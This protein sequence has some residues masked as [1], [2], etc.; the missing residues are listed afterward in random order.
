MFRTH[1]CKQLNENLVGEEVTICG[2]VDSRRDH[3]KVTFIDLR[4]RYGKVQVV[5]TPKPFSQ[6]YKVAK[7]LHNEYVVKLKAEVNPRPKGTQN[8]NLNT[9]KIELFAKEL[10]VISEA[11]ELPFALDAAEQVG[12]DIRYHHRYLDL[13]R[14]PL[15]DNFIV[16]H[17]FN[18]SFRKFLNNQD[19][20]EIETPFLTKSTPEGAR[21]FI[22][23]SRLQPHSFYALPQSP[24]LFKQLLMIAGMDKYYQIVRCFR[25]EDLRRD[26]Q[27]EFSQLDM[28]MS[29]IKEDAILTLTEEMLKQVFKEV[30]GQEL[31]TPFPRINYQQAMEEHGTDAPDIGEGDWRF[32]WVLNFPL[33]EFNNDQQRW[34]SLHHP[35]T[36]P[37]TD[38]I[39]H[40]D[41][42]PDKVK[43][44]AY[45]LV[46]NGTEIAS[47]S[48]RI[49]SA[50][51]QQKIFDIIGISK[52]EA[53][54]RFGF[55]LRAFQYGTPPHGGIAFGLDRLYSII[56]KSESI[57]E[58]IA[59]PKTQ[60][61][62]CPLTEAPAQVNKEQLD[63]LSIK[64]LEEED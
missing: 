11:A 60:K 25:D 2:W 35:F 22:L 43:A 17:N 20:L 41:K 30:L 47:G 56:T 10:E 37:T 55:L 23:P 26:R 3:G 52:Q 38:T 39:E 24:Q 19:F 14:K 49:H 7:E 16:R 50:S 8:P 12:E 53:E 29:F 59:F 9:G 64:L 15:L 13:R 40:L 33:F 4:D 48:I 61:G 62:I 21:D 54:K 57:R 32:T 51:L 58:V 45:D 27:P 42:A 46:L 6:A 28:E 63:E 44:R 31:K 1:T 34:N 36:A 5:F 18:Q